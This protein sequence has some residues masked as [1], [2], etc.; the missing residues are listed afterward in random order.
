MDWRLGQVAGVSEHGVFRPFIASAAVLSFAR[1]AW[2]HNRFLT[3]SRQSVI[4]ETMWNESGTRSAFGQYPATDESIH[5]APS[6]V[7]I[8]M[9][10]RWLRRQFFEEQVED[11]FA[12]SV[13]R[14]NHPLAFVVDDDGD[15]RVALPVAGLVHADR[16][17]PVEHAWHAGFQ[18]AATRPAMS[19]AVL[20]ATWQE[21][22][23][24]LPVGDRHQP[25]AFQRVNRMPGSA[26]GTR[27]TTTPCT[28]HSTR[29]AGPTSSTPWCR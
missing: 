8:L 23:H 13:V 28:R 4:Q 5:L 19:P 15:I 9:E 12:V 14:P 29:G 7:T 22:A 6:P 25:R 1:L 24:G 2:F 26:H 16:R 10:A 3:R 17:E 11:L 18:P 27:D 21:T 20:H